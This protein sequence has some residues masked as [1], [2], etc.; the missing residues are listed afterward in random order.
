ML[1][2]GNKESDSDFHAERITSTVRSMPHNCCQIS[3]C[4]ENR[5]GVSVSTCLCV[6]I[7]TRENSDGPRHFLLKRTLCGCVGSFWS[8]TLVRLG[9]GATMY[10]DA[11][12]ACGGGGEATLAFFRED[13]EV[14]LRS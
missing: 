9:T 13:I 5:F 12:I 14:S 1:L 3:N 4:R 10:I 11:N 6:E 2:P 8:D 7:K